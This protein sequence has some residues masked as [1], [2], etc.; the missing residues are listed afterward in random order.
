MRDWRNR[1]NNILMYDTLRITTTLS[2]VIPLSYPLS[3]SLSRYLSRPL[4]LILWND[5]SQVGV[6]LVVEEDGLFW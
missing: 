3:L 5:D 1:L 6:A 2:S 4:P